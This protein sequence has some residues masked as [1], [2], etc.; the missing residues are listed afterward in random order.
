M[1]FMTTSGIR[2]SGLVA[3]TVGTAPPHSSWVNYRNCAFN[4]PQFVRSSAVTSSVDEQQVVWPRL[5]VMQS[6]TW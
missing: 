2:H 6:V 3:R 4:E 1:N 5:S